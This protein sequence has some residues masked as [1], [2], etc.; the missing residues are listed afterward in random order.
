MR[1]YAD[2]PAQ[3]I[4]L[5]TGSERFASYGYQYKRVAAITGDVFYHAPRLFD[6]RAY[7]KYDDTYIYRFNTRSWLNNTNATYTDYTGSLRPAY[8]GVAH[9]SEVAFVFNNPEFVGPW[10]GYEALSDQMSAQWINFVHGGD[11]NGVDLPVWPRYGKGVGKNL[12]L[13]TEAQGGSYVEDDTYRLEG[14][15]YLIK[16]ARR[17]HV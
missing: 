12:V 10:E 17:R 11:P 13:Q 2:D 16:W 7:A 15:E 14:R 1:L 8:K 6:A 4:P 5:N 9:F 3:G